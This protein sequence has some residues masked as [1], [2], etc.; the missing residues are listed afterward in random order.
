MLS[1]QIPPS[2]VGTNCPA[3]PSGPACGIGRTDAV[4]AAGPPTDAEGRVPAHDCPRV[5]EEPL[6]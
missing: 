5:S 1:G 4:L 6:R 2:P 3:P